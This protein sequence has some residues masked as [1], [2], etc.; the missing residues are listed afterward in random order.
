VKWRREE[1]S[2]MEHLGVVEMRL[3]RKRVSRKRE[4]Q[5]AAATARR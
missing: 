3:E 2:W 4:S 5:L 1:R